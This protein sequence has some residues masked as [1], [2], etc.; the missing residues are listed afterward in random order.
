MVCVRN[1]VIEGI[2][3][4]LV[5]KKRYA[6]SER[7]G[8]R[9]VSAPHTASAADTLQGEEVGRLTIRQHTCTCSAIHTHGLTCST[10]K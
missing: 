6:H 5:K 1:S 10:V 4:V 3:S 9:C 8:Q 7:A 2:N